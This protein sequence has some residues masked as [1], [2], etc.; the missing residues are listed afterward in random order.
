MLLSRFV[1]REN[2]RLYDRIARHP[3]ILATPPVPPGLR[4][5]GSDPDRDPVMYRP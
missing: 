2:L 5:A 3:W 4:L 1:V